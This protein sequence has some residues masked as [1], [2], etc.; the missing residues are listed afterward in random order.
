[1][2][3]IKKVAVKTVKVAS[4]VQ[5]MS[6]KKYTVKGM[7]LRMLLEAIIFFSKKGIDRV[8]KNKALQS[9]EDIMTKAWTKVLGEV[10]PVVKTKKK[11]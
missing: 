9:S 10:T 11:D 1:M 4:K 5:A 2:D 7:I 8:N 3:K 6:P